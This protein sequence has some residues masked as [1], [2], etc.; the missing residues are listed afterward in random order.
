LKNPHYIGDLVQGRTKVRSVVDKTRD[1]VAKENWIVIKDTH[2]PIITREEFE[3]VQNIMK[4]RSAKRPKAKIHLFTN[5]VYCADC[6]TGLWFM[7]NRN[8]YVC[9]RFKKHGA[10][11]CSSHSI[12]EQYIK[13]KVLDDLKKFISAS[14]DERDLLKKIQPKIKKLTDPSKPKHYNSGSKAPFLALLIM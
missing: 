7:K 13:E 2:D 11:A 12:K 10:N 1:E 5:V 8:G 4:S 9:G 3:A 14:V 6:G